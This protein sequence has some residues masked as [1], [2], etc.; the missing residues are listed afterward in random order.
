MGSPP[1]MRGPR[2]SV[3]SEVGETRITPAYAGTTSSSPAPKGMVE[4]HP[5]VCG[6]HGNVPLSGMCPLGSPPRMRGPRGPLRRGSGLLRIT[7]AY[8]GTT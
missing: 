2:E 3:V 1:R 4:D 8:A 6:D 5:R 7:P